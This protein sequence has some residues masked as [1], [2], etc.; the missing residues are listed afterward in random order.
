MQS[1]RVVEH[2]VDCSHIRDYPAA[3]ANGDADRPQ[4]S[5]K[6]Y[7]PHDNPHPQPGDVTIIGAHAN[8]FTKVS[9]LV[10]R[11]ELH[12]TCLRSYMSLYGMTSTSFLPK[13]ASGFGLSGWRMCGTKANLVSLMKRCLAMIVSK[14]LS[15]LVWK[16]S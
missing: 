5:V 1:Y 9:K 10:Y 13:L 15:S 8:G 3:T 14:S 2:T 12:L 6:Q 7:I 11:K 16:Y 4:I